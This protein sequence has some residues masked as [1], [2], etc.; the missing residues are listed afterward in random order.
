M[1]GPGYKVLTYNEKLKRDKYQVRIFRDIVTFEN[2]KAVT[3]A[4]D[5]SQLHWGG[6]IDLPEGEEVDPALP[7]LEPLTGVPELQ[8]P[9][10]ENSAPESVVSERQLALPGPGG[11]ERIL[12]LVVADEPAQ[13]QVHQAPI[14]V[15]PDTNGAK[16]PVN[17]TSMVDGDGRPQRHKRVSS[18]SPTEHVPPMIYI[19]IMQWH[20]A[21]IS[22]GFA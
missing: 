6:H 5:E 21:S 1:E 12:E 9:L 14:E 18:Q 4:Q 15:N 2:L 19:F 16:Q 22:L 17:Q 7:E 13:T 20:V 10:P 11:A 8:A 3:G